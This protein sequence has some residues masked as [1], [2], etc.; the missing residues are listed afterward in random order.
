MPIP[1]YLTLEGET[2]G[3]ISSGAS[4]EESLGSKS[5]ASQEDTIQVQ[6]FEHNIYMHTDPQSGQPTGVPFHGDLTITK[7]VD[8]TS[9]M[10][11]QAMAKGENIITGEIKWYRTAPTG[12]LEH[13]FS[14]V[15]EQSSITNITVIIPDTLNPNTQ[16]LPE[17]EKV[18]FRYKK[19]TWT[20]EVAGTEGTY[21][22]DGEE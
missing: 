12:E 13:Y 16:Y 10:L 5:K 4:G 19:I 6:A 1:A 8:K 18:T 21:A 20:H 2:Q 11:M 7:M 9:P 14:T 22:W 15:F 17:L 3:E